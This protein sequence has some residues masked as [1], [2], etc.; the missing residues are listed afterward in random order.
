MAILLIIVIILIL[1]TVLPKN[2]LFTLF[3]F[4]YDKNGFNRRNHMQDGHKRFVELR[5]PITFTGWIG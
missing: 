5:P 2:P 1:Y 4:G 3:D